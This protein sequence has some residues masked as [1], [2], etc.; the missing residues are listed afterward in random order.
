M[1]RNLKVLGLAFVAMLAMSAVVASAAMAEGE[2][3]AGAEGEINLVGK[4]VEGNH[5][6]TAGSAAVEC[7]EAIFEGS[8]ENGD[9][10]IDTHP[11][12]N[13]CTAF[14]F[15]GASV[16]TTGCDYTFTNEGTI[17]E[18][19]YTGKVHIT[20]SGSNKI[21]VS[22]GTCALEIG[23]QGP[24]STVKVIDTTGTSPKTIMVNA[25]VVTGITYNVTKDGFLCP[26]SG[27][28]VKTDGKY[29]GNTTVEGSSEGSPVDIEWFM[30]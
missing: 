13:E 27:T 6:F 14:G 9:T 11:T 23:S 7:E 21:K 24:L 30:E 20:C 15:L 29:D 12:Y 17:G 16:S 22:A 5:V 10:V 25:D 19:E 26:L 28:G 3:K 8:A 4:Q 18:D 2:F 1:S